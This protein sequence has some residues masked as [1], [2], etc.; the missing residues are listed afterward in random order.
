MSDHVAVVGPE[1]LRRRIA[2]LEDENAR[3]RA[4]VARLRR[5]DADWRDLTRQTSLLR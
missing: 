3:L 1:A 5:Q 4:Q 2:R